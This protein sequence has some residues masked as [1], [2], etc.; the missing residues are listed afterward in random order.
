VSLVVDGVLVASALDGAFGPS[1]NVVL[2]PNQLRRERLGPRGSVLE[3]LLPL[4]RLPAG[5]AQWHAPAGVGLE[6]TLSWWTTGRALEASEAIT[7]TLADG[8]VCVFVLDPA[9][10][11]LV[12]EAGT[13]RSRVRAA[14]RVDPPGRI[15]WAA[16]VGPSEAA[17]RSVLGCLSSLPA[18]EAVAS[19]W[20]SELHEEYLSVRSG[21]SEID[22]AL[23]WSKAYLATEVDPPP[24]LVRLSDQLACGL[25]AKARA[26]LQGLEVVA[27]P[28]FG[29]A[30]AEYLLWTGDTAAPH[31]FAAA[32]DHSIDQSAASPEARLWTDRAANGLEGL[33]YRKRALALRKSLESAPA[34]RLPMARGETG[35]AG[36]PR[37]ALPDPEGSYLA[38]RERAARLAGGHVSSGPDGVPSDLVGLLLGAEAEAAL[39]RLRLAPNF[40]AHLTEFEVRRIRAGDGRVDFAYSREGNLHRIRLSPSGGGLPLNVTLMPSLPG[41]TLDAARLGRKSV[42]LD[43]EKVGTRVTPRLRLPVD[44]ERI[45]ELEVGGG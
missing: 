23:V 14:L 15:T 8:R 29:P 21:V 22:Q 4:P 34:V 26:T 25:F 30:F 1:A 31:D 5:V 44:G 18:Q 13:D 40:P 6:A 42:D 19:G 28:E 11:D 27:S 12:I 45:L 37:A 3:D 43:W 20:L 41:Q 9:P 32:L 10:S 39:G 38:W 36:S 33:G 7:C 16:S 24:S 17:A 35:D 2:A